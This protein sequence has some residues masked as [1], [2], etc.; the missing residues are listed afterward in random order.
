[1][2]QLH[3][4]PAKRVAWNLRSVWMMM[5]S[6]ILKTRALGDIVHVIIVG[7]RAGLQDIQGAQLAKRGVLK[8]AFFAQPI[9]CQADFDFVC[10]G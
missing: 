5:W 4:G 9:K 6:R 8:E 3:W 10:S 7:M 2:M 1:M